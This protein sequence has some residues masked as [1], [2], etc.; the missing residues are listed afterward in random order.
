M[1]LYYFSSYMLQA[2]DIFPVDYFVSTTKKKSWQGSFNLV[3][4]LLH[5]YFNKTD[6]TV[7]I[8]VTIF[9]YCEA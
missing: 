9:N 7:P 2:T 1:R 8:T 4:Y 5:F 6:S 3:S